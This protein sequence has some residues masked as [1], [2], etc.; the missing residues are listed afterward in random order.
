[1]LKHT[2]HIQNPYLFSI[3]LTTIAPILCLS[4]TVPNLLPNVDECK[5]FEICGNSSW[6]RDESCKFFN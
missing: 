3:G 1:M 2:F 6:G 4:L 5:I